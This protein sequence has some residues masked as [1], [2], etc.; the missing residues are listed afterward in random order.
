MWGTQRRDSWIAPTSDNP[1]STELDCER[2]HQELN[3]FSVN[4]I[5]RGKI[6]VRSPMRA[7]SDQVEPGMACNE[8]RDVGRSTRI[9]ASFA[10]LGAA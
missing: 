3:T 4:S 5:S 9:S 8:A 7:R 6:L 2:S 10:K 1:K